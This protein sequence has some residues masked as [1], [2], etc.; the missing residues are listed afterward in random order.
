MNQSDAHQHGI[1][2]AA[3]SLVAGIFAG[4]CGML[5]GHPFDSLK[6]RLQ[7][8]KRLSHV[9]ADWSTFRELYR[10]VIPPVSTAGVTQSI[11]FALYEY[12]RR[13]LK[14]KYKIGSGDYLKVVFYSGCASGSIISVLT[15]PI[16]VVKIQQQVASNK[17]VIQCSA[18]IFRNGGVRSFYRGFL[19]M[20]IGESIGRGVYLGTYE[21]CKLFIGNARSKDFCGI[22]DFIDACR[23]TVNSDH[24]RANETM[25]T[26]VVAAACAGVF[27]WLV[28]YPCDM[29]KSRM[30]LDHMGT[31]YR[32]M[33]HCLSTL[34]KE[35]GIPGIYRGLG[36][37]VL[38]AAPVAGTI[39]PIYEYTKELVDSSLLPPVDCYS[40]S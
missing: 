8:G 14:D 25:S 35:G 38:R 17:S 32:G 23:V 7:V 16:S 33:W 15:N 1:K 2:Q 9:A 29:V 13:H 20:F 3:S 27:S 12:F 24:V 40:T 22:D 31:T 36:Y 28:M 21:T 10:G 18:D 4:G 11:N 30:Q 6:V 19:A 26:R 39:L 37:T 5:V 34:W